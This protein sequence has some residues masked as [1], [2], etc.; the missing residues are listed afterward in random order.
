VHLRVAILAFDSSILLV[1]IPPFS[2]QATRPIKYERQALNAVA[3]M[4][5][6][7]MQKSAVHP[8]AWRRK[9]AADMGL[10]KMQCRFGTKGEFAEARIVLDWWQTADHSSVE[11]G[12]SIP[13]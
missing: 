3:G 9:V 13:P 2:V 1:Q 12:K 7:E 8:C 10:T 11:Q 6:Y 4:G 5:A